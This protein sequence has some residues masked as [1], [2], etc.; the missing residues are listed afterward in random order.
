MNLCAGVFVVALFATPILPAA[1]AGS[2]RFSVEFTDS[3]VA[4]YAKGSLAV[5]EEWFPKIQELLFG[6]D[7]SFPYRDIRLV[8]GEQKLAGVANFNI[9]HISSQWVKQPHELDYR[10][11]VIHELTHVVQDY[12]LRLQCNGWRAIPCFFQIRFSRANAPEWLGEGIADYIT[13]TYFTKTNEPKLRLDKDGYLFGYTDTIPYLYGLQEGKLR[14]DGAL[15]ARKVPAGKG[16]R[17]GY[18]VASAF[19]LWLETYKDK[20]IVR[21]LNIALNQ[22][23]Y[24]AMLFQR[25]CG[26]PLDTLW[27]EFLA[28]CMHP[29]HATK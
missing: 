28:E 15:R 1:A 23:H 25:H 18:T 20:D 17:H 10:A 27:R 12:A 29:Q 9:V 19:L 5:S 2:P 24:S 6:T 21:K 14:P 11:V 26:A 7:H 3:A 16:Y 13:Y 4:E 8:F 22:R